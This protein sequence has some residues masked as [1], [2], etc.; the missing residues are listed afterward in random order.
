M[1]KCPK[2]SG[3]MNPEEFMNISKGGLSWDYEGW[4][5]LYCGEVVDALILENR[6]KGRDTTKKGSF[7]GSGKGRKR[8]L[9]HH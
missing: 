4:R 6:M 8:V 5:C 1:M 9:C 7:S 3:L 2:C